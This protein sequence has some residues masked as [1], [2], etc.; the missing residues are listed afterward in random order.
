MPNPKFRHIL[1]GGGSG[2]P[3]MEYKQIIDISKFIKT[4]NPDIPIYLMS[5]PPFNTEILKKYQEA[6]IT[7][8]AFNIEIWDRNL[9][10]QLM[11]GK[12]IDPIRDIFKCLERINYIMGKYR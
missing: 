4:I 1:I 9:A 8:V 7:E 11:P 3:F 2:D 5:L 6:G 12:R 10:R